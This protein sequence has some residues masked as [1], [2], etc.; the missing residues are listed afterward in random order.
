MTLHDLNGAIPAVVV[1]EATGWT[2][3]RVQRAAETLTELLAPAGL[4]V[5]Q[6]SGRLALRAV[7]DAHADATLAARQHPRASLSQRLVTPNRARLAYRA[8]HEPLSQHAFS[9]D[10]RREIA[11]LMRVGIVEPDVNRDMTV[12][13]KVR[14]SLNP[15]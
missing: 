10:D 13:D 6:Q 7:S 3:P 2:L 9:E 11:V 4:T 8:L 12:S 14:R 5:Q 15:D 1:A